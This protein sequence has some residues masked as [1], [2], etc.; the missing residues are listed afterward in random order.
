MMNWGN[1][2]WALEPLYIQMQDLCKRIGLVTLL[3]K[4]IGYFS[5]VNG[6]NQ[7]KKK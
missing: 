5:G 6:K 2:K 3:Q 1:E 7:S 4:V